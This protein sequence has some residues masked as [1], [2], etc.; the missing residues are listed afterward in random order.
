M[1]E[2]VEEGGKKWEEKWK[3]ESGKRQEVEGGMGRG[4]AGRGRGRRK[5]KGRGTKVG[6]TEERQ[7]GGRKRKKGVIEERYVYSFMKALLPSPRLSKTSIRKIISRR[8]FQCRKKKYN[9][10]SS[11]FHSFELLNDI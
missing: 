2:W 10:R 4:R 9:K 3:G 8:S 1:E 5:G 7:A 6:R 11:T